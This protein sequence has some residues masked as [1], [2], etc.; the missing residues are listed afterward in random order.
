MG[1]YHKL[2]NLDKREFVDPHKLG[3][4]LKLWE[5]LASH[6]GTGSAMIILLA[7]ASNGEG[8]GDLKNDEILGRWRGDRIAMVGDYDDK[9]M[10]VVGTETPTTQDR[11]FSG[12]AIYQVCGEVG[13]DWKD[14]SDAV[15]AVIE[16]ELDGKFSGKGWRD[17]TFSDGDKGERGMKPD[18]I[19]S[20]QR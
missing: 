15:A 14:V 12:A 16:R 6:P 5:Q 4:G 2:V 17:F 20:V 18:M 9:A 8:G 7:S 10:Y 19:L 13:S 1:Q 3:C 11:V